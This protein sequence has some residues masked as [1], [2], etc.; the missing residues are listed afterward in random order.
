MKNRVKFVFCLVVV[1][2][3]LLGCGRREQ[4]CDSGACNPEDNQKNAET[5]AGEELGPDL[6]Y[7]A[8]VKKLDNIFKSGKK[9][10][11]ELKSVISGG[12]SLQI[13]YIDRE[14]YR[15]EGTYENKWM[16]AKK[17]SSF[18]TGKRYDDGKY[19][20][21]IWADNK[22]K[23]EDNKG[24]MACTYGF[25]PARAF[26]INDLP[27]GAFNGVSPELIDTCRT[28]E[29]EIRYEPPGEIKTQLLDWSGL[30]QMNA[31]GV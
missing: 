2:V 29:G 11:C 9:Y 7:G 25:K 8:A 30:G 12:D 10:R 6:E 19:C 16:D 3:L 31:T 1:I 14:N 17:E 21:Y 18:T 28:W 20:V 5:G 4:S 26:E 13:L 22:Q 24:L 15:G 23:K 27:S